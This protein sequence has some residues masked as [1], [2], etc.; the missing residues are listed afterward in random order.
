MSTACRTSIGTRRIRQAR[1][2]HLNRRERSNQSSAAAPERDHAWSKQRCDAKR[3]TN[4]PTTPKTMAILV[5]RRTGVRKYFMLG[6]LS[7]LEVSGR[8]AR[9]GAN[10]FRRPSREERGEGRRR[11]HS[12]QTLRTLRSS[13]FG[14]VREGLGG[15]GG[16]AGFESLGGLT[17]HRRRIGEKRSR[18]SNFFSG[19]VGC[20]SA[21]AG[22]DAGENT[23]ARSLCQGVEGPFLH[24]P[25]FSH[26][27]H[28]GLLSAEPAFRPLDYPDF[29]PTFLLAAP[30]FRRA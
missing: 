30:R 22:C 23:G 7:G 6:V 20:A 11:T 29:A 2:A 16:A 3:K 10:A 18:F 24:F 8:P 28:F 14:F 19:W 4:S 5:E 25:H 12:R 26:N 21:K 1:S 27:L 9:S 13:S 15:E 17:P